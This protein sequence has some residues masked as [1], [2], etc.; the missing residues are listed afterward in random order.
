MIVG[1]NGIIEFYV[2]KSVNILQ[3]ENVFML[4]CIIYELMKT[5]NTIKNK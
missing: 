2:S 3:Y 5:Y 4:L 1:D